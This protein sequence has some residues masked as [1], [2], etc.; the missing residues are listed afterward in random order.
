MAAFSIS[1][2][3]PN[4]ALLLRTLPVLVYIVSARVDFPLDQFPIYT[5]AT[6]NIGLC[7]ASQS[8]SYSISFGCP[9]LTPGLCLCTD[10]L[11]S[12]SVM[13]AIRSCV[14]YE[15][16]EQQTKASQLWNSYCHTNGGVEIIHDETRLQD[17]PL[18]TQITSDARSCLVSQTYSSSITFGCSD[19]TIAPCLCGNEA[20]SVQ[21]WGSASSCMYYYSK[22]Q[23]SSGYQLWQSYCNVN[24]ATP[25]SRVV[26]TPIAVSGMF[27]DD[28]H[29][30]L[31]SN[32]DFSNI[33]T[34][35]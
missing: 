34:H 9:S 6:S 28:F 19:Y 8:S 27:H 32:F 24:L 21:L 14:Y 11:K 30:P 15:S 16:W 5:Q 10:A 26:G 4:V 1:S 12:S 2:A 35:H 33:H 22:S 18:Y 3:L 17:I 29:L 31:S 7:V 25:A 20:S 13:S 23:I